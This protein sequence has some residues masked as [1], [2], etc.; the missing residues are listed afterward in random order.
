LQG[1]KLIKTDLEP[2]LQEIMIRWDIPGLAI[3]I[4]EGNDTVYA[5][6]FGVRSLATKEP[7]T[8]DS[9]F[10]VQS[11]S[12]CFVATAVMQLTEC[13]KLELDAPLVHYLPYFQLDDERYRQITLRQILSHTSGMPDIDEA[14]YVAWVSQPEYDDGSAERFV[15]NL[16]HRKLIFNPGERF[17]YSNIAYNVLGD[18]LSKVS[19]SSFEDLMKDHLLAPAGMSSSTFWLPGVPTELL[20]WPHLR[21]PGMKV[22]PSYPYHRADAPSSFL[23]TTVL[24]MC[25][26]GIISLKRGTHLGRRILSPSGY[27]L[28]WAPIARR[29]EPPSL[30]EEMGLGWTLGHFKGVR[31]VCHGGAGFGATA[32]LIILPEQHRAAVVLCNEESNACNRVVQAVAD[33]LIGQKPQMKPVSWMVPISRAL[34]EGG[35]AG[36]YVRYAE[37]SAGD[38]Q[39]YYFHEYDLD[40]LALQLFTAGNVGLA[41]DVLG[42]NIYVYPEHADSY[43]MRARLYRESGAGAQSKADLRRALSLE[44]ANPFAAEILDTVQQEAG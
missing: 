20:A 33:T 43:L 11:I 23:H 22:S 38:G 44:P 2:V 19:A 21:S 18:L 31:T 14:D 9:V 15:R 1:S 13:G 24:D 29:S 10:C 36:A 4:V 28:M 39:E 37:L 5:A 42:L 25:R 27:E 8:L 3:G 30:Y 41:I 16:S 35:I 6:G 12:K 7:V 34:A 26:W 32:F 17:S 40:S